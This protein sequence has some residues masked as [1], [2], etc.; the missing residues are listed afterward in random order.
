MCMFVRG[1]MSE[2]KE[3]K[4][5][6]LAGV[7]AGDSSICLCGAEEE[8]LCYR[9]Y[10][11]ED[12]AAH[13]SF[14]EVTWLLTRGELPSRSELESFRHQQKLQRDIPDTLKNILEALPPSANHMDVL[15]T[16]C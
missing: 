11:I 16:A 8:S 5:G 9:G 2:T 7:V 1:I 13:G 3:K 12:M 15:R 10:S 14:E 4:T 6:G